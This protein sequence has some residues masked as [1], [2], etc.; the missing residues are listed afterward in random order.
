MAARAV[1]WRDDVLVEVDDLLHEAG[2]RGEGDV[3]CRRCLVF[4]VGV[5][6]PWFV[7]TGNGKKADGEKK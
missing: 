3:F 5:F 6:A 1:D 7:I 2:K 4:E